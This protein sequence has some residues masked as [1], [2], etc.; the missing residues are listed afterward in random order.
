MTDI[1][2]WWWIA[3]TLLAAGAQTLRNVMQKSLIK[4][5]GT[6]GATHVRFLFGLP[7]G[8]LFL[9]IVLM[10]LGRSIPA[11]SLNFFG[12]VVLGGVAQIAATALMLAAMNLRSFVVATAYAKTEPVQLALFGLI[13][14]GDRLSLGTSTAIVVATVGV[15]MMSWPKSTLL[16]DP[17]V[18]ADNR[19]SVLFGL[20][21]GG[22]F[23]ISVV[24][25]RGAIRALDS[26]SFVLAATTTLAIGQMIQTG[27]L[28]SY[29]LLRSP[30]TLVEIFRVWRSSLTAG[31]MGAF[32]SQFWFLAFAIENAARVRT[33]ALVE[34]LFAQAISRQL[35]AQ[36]TTWR[37][38]LGIALVVIGVAILLNV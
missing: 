23:A 3:F 21:S 24:G 6:I 9:A 29:L 1:P 17:A 27:L 34:I 5:V 18:S 2:G 31:F 16:A 19:R 37:E 10:V 20:A 7:F 22:L 32:G 14:L 11:L 8:L 28:S 35:F 38:G 12:W 15:L 4:S 33:L 36:G 13:F 25:F 30:S 26:D